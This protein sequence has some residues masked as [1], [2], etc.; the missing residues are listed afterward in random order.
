MP[1]ARA[2]SAGFLESGKK[3]I[4]STVQ[5]FPFILDEIGNEQRGRRFAILIDEAH[6]SQ[7]GKTAAAVHLALSE[8]GAEGEDETT[9]DAINRIM[10]ARKFL[11]NAELLRLHRHAQEQD[12]GDLRRDVRCG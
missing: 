3:I 1:P 2:I 9:E 6:S 5:K 11:P 7:G 10:V 12:A 4:I 8:A